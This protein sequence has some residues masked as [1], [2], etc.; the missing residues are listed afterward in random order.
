V[1]A[2]TGIAKPDIQVTSYSTGGRP[3]HIPDLTTPDNN[4]EPYLV[5]VN[6][7]L[8]QDYFPQV[9]ST[10][11]GEPEQTVPKSY[12]ERVCKQF[13]QVGA[14]GTSLLFSSGDRGVGGTGKCYSNDGKNTFKFLSNFPV[15]CPY[16]TGVGATMNFEPE[17]SAY[18]PAMNRSDGSFRDLYSSGSG[19]STYWKRPSYQDKV[20]PAYIKGLNGAYDGLYNKGTYP[21]PRT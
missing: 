3:P 13:A 11:Y 20:V 15:G 17:E 2:I 14:R 12:A 18:R 4:N 1:Q 9:I 5:W 6:W 21:T 8:E 19:F 7:L 10:S 16:V